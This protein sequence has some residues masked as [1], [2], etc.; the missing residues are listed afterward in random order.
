MFRHELQYEPEWYED[1]TVTWDDVQGPEDVRMFLKA[2]EK[3]LKYCAEKMGSAELF[4]YVGTAATARDVAALADLLDGP[5]SPINMWTQGHGS[6]VASYVM[7]RA[8]LPSCFGSTDRPI[9][10]QCSLRCAQHLYV[11]QH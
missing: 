9:L 2:Q 11:A 3:T 7:K 4:K 6:V 5:G 10:L 8:L 1:G